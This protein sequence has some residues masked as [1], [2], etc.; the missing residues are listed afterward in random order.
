MLLPQV[1][2]QQNQWIAFDLDDTLHSFTHAAAIAN[3]AVLETVS[4]E[5]PHVGKDT[6]NT[7]YQGFF[8]TMLTSFSDGR[9]SREYRMER[10]LAL[11]QHFGLPDH[12]AESLAQ[13]YGCSFE[14][15]LIE[16][17][18]ATSTLRSLHKHGI[19]IAV[20]SQ[21]PHDAQQRTLSRLSLQKYVDLLITSNQER[22]SKQDGLF[23]RFLAVTKAIPERTLMIG[24]S[25]T[26]DVYPARAAGLHAAL[27][28]PHGLS[29]SSQ[30]YPIVQ[31][32]GDV[33][34]LYR[35]ING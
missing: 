24:D 21:A 18:N 29:A 6:I 5:H 31:D 27:Y 12:R 35:E 17:K 3:S 9:T 11:L 33:L 13:E 7:V 32:L 14:A 1:A 26:H 28:D 25:L 10:F 2:H 16:N 8:K 23:A 30:D 19:N 4:N 20:I 22:V 34:A 15:A